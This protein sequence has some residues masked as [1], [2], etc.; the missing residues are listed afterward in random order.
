[1]AEYPGIVSSNGHGNVDPHGPPTPVNIEA[2]ILNGFIFIILFAWSEFLQIWYDNT[3]KS[4]GD[5]GLV[6]N[7]LVFT[8]FLTVLFAIAA[9]VTYNIYETNKL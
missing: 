5:Y 1:M 3:F 2:I 7:G 9:Y 8:I 4:D 6:W